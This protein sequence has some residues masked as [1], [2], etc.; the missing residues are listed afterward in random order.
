[1]VSKLVFFQAEINARRDIATHNT[2]R[3]E[4]RERL[5]MFFFWCCMCVWFF[6][7]FFF[8]FLD[9]HVD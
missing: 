6:F 4:E 1:V 3:K 8:S 7:L 5:L 9:V 2:K